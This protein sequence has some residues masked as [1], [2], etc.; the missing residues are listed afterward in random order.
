VQHRRLRE[1][2]DDLVRRRQNG[3]GAQVQRARR[4]VRVEAEVRAPGLVDDQRHARRMAHRRARLHVGGHPV[5]GRRDD[6]DAARRSGQLDRGLE[7]LGRDPVR[8]PQL[9]LV[10]RR[11]VGRDAAREHEP[12]DDA[13]VRVALHD[14]RGAQ[15]RQRQRE[16]VVALTRAVGE[17]PGAGRAVRLGGELLGALVG[18]RRRPEVDPVD[19]GRHVDH[20]RRLAERRA[21][22]GIGARAALVPGH[23]EARR[24]AERVAPDRVEVRRGGLR[25]VDRA[26]AGLVS[27]RH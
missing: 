15:R 26:G 8:H 20:Q 21:Q 2:A 16:R 5:V 19:V 27:Q 9:V 17:E 3:V 10:L 1:R 11:H 22:A 13:G 6:E 4:Q 18:G 25:G 23:V 24:A 7:R 14:D 12:V